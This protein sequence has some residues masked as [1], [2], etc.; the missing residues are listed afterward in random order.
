MTGMFKNI[1]V[2][3]DGSHLAEQALPVAAYLARKL[4]ARVTLLHV[5][6]TH[7]PETVHGEPHLRSSEQAGEYLDT[8]ARKES[9]LEIEVLR[10]VHSDQ[11]GDVARSIVEH[12]GELSPDLI[13]M[14]THGGHP[15]RD[16]L[17]GSI[18]Q[19]VTSLG[20]IPVL[21]IHPQMEG[22]PGSFQCRRL[23]VPLD[24]KP[25]H[26]AP[27]DLVAQLARVCGAALHLVMVVP[28]LGTVSGEDTA[29]RKFS[30]GTLSELL[31]QEEQGAA[32]YLL[33]LENN[34]RQSGLEVQAEV[35]RGEPVE[36]IAERAVTASIDVVVVGTHGK[37]GV[38]AF[39]SGSFA[40]RLAVRSNVPLLLIPLQGT[41]QSESPEVND[42]LQT[43]S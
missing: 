16:R 11:V 14:C 39:W 26:E 5:V 33:G 32:A 17:F 10:H 31:D 19:K 22:E 20:T 38:S 7:P 21:V 41:D 13:V 18:A 37:A 23:L 1:L 27:L 3:L 36:S 8:V 42:S 28:T 4:S 43:S 24:G 30:P 9:P 12:T 34:L 40:A 2:P 25:E 35:L 29:R 15:A 6:E